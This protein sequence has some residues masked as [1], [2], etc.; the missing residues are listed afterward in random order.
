MGHEPTVEARCKTCGP[1]LRIIEQ[2]NSDLKARLVE[3]EARLA[4]LKRQ[5]ARW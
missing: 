5:R 4:A 3:L 1:Y 2:E